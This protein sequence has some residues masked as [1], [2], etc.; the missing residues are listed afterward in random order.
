MQ[1]GLP[2]VA[3]RTSGPGQVKRLAS[4]STT[5]IIIKAE[6]PFYRVG[7]FN[8]QVG[9]AWRRVRDQQRRHQLG[10]LLKHEK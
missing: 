4:V 8:S 3:M 1:A 2:R 9:I 6:P 7:D 5:Q 10:H